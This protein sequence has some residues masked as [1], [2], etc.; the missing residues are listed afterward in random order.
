MKFIKIL[1]LS[2]VLLTLTMPSLAAAK[3]RAILYQ[4]RFLIQGANA[5]APAKGQRIQLKFKKSPAQ[6][7]AA[8]TDLQ[9]F[10]N[11]RLT[12]C[13]D[14][15]PAELIFRS[16]F[17]NHRLYRVPVDISCGTEDS[18]AK[19]YNFCL[20]SLTFGKY[21]VSSPDKLDGTC[22]LCKKD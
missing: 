8:V 16:D 14:D 10:A 12:R 19:A 3:P 20:Y 22:R 18:P 11:F 4:F 15:D 5:Y 17:A 2:A 7:F 9:G 13:K 6:T 21:L 1:L